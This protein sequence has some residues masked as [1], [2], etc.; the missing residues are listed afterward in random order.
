[1]SK[2]ESPISGLPLLFA[3]AVLVILPVSGKSAEGKQS[4][5]NDQEANARNAKVTVLY[6]GPL[7]HDQNWIIKYPPPGPD[8]YKTHTLGGTCSM[9]LGD[10]SNA[11]AFERIAFEA[12]RE[13][14]GIWRMVWVD[15]VSG[16]ATGRRLY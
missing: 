9:V 10:V 8:N 16:E 14:L 1:M 6:E 3:L 15:T 7:S 5:D 13:E 11:S 2:S 12:E 4:N